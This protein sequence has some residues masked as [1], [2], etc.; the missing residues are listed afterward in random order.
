MARRIALATAALVSLLA[1]SGAGGSGAQT[2]KRGGT[3][4]VPGIFGGTVEPSCLNPVRDCIRAFEHLE[5]VLEGAF[6]TTPN[7][8]R[9][10]LVTKVEY[11]RTPPFTLTYHIRPEA[12]WSDGVPITARDFVFTH[13]ALRR[14]PPPNS[15]HLT[16]VRTVRA[17]DAKTVDVVLKTRIALW[18][19]S[20]FWMVL[21]R[22][23]L[24]GADLDR[25][26]TDRVDNPKTGQPIGSGPFL[27]ERWERGERLVLRRN[28]R[29][30][31][32]H[33]A[34][35]DRV[36]IRFGIGDPAAA[37]RSGA[38]DV[39]QI[40]L[41]QD[42]GSARAFLGIPGFT[43]RYATG[44]RWE[45]LE[46]RIGPGGHPALRNKLVRRALAYGVDRV[47]LARAIFGGLVPRMQ[48]A[49]SAVF[50]PSRPYYEPNWRRYRHRPDLARRLLGRAG[51]GRGADGIYVCEGRPLALRFVAN[52]GVASRSQAF[53]LVQAQLR[54]IGIEVQPAYVPGAALLGQVIP[55][56]DWDVWMIAYLLPGTG[57]VDG[58]V[59]RCQGTS[60][61][62]GYCQR[63]VTGELDQ[64][65]RILDPDAHARALNRADARMALDVPVLPLWQEP[66]FAAF[67]STIHGF[68]PTEPLVTWNAENWW[69]A[70]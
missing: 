33:P 55:S 30:W 26:W 56:G 67:R 40:R 68:V 10:N 35:L 41:G 18:K 22:H 5:D 51:C 38:L 49:D 43:H 29:Y 13:Q 63:L 45:H 25:V 59:F 48:P 65:D 47:A 23:A 12:R 34:Y 62:T 16:H 32:R 70:E 61:V 53:E 46:I 27:V 31:G 50:L 57:S 66:S 52:T 21:P 44:A 8:V 9:P 37:L 11:T 36:V 2:P 1:V 42:P 17:V 7:R 39:Y 28:S 14:V 15:V 60:N 24:R 3:V 19:T 54:R 69:L 4:V 58:S 64:A 6:E 20:L